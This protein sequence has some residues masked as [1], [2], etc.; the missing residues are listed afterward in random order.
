[1]LRLEGKAQI[2]NLKEISP[3]LIAGTLITYE[4]VGEEFQ[5]TFLKAVFVGDSIDDIIRCGIKDKDKVNV[6]NAILKSRKYTNKEGVE[7]T[8]MQATVF[9]L[10]PYVAEVD[11]QESKGKFKR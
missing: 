4:K 2:T 7:V 5:P 11:K 8:E 1:M 9:N 6:V 10:T 3:K